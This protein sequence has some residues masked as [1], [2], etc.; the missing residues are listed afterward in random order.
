MNKKTLKIAGWA[1]GLSVAV[2]G[3]GAIA[4]THVNAPVETE[5]L[6]LLLGTYE[7]TGA[8]T[9][10]KSNGAPGTVTWNGGAK[11]TALANNKTFSISGL[12]DYTITDALI[13]IRRSSNSKA[14]ATF[15]WKFDSESGTSVSFDADSFTNSTSFHDETLFTGLSKNGSTF[16][17]VTS[18]TGSS[19]YLESV[20]LY[21]SLNSSDPSVTFNN[22]TS[23]VN[24]GST[25]ANAA[26]GANLGGAAISY[27]SDNEAVA[28]VTSSGV[29]AGVAAGNATITASAVVG[30]VRY[31]DSYNITVLATPVYSGGMNAFDW[32]NYENS[33][34]YTDAALIDSTSVSGKSLSWQASSFET[35]SSKSVFVLGDY[36]T[37]NGTWNNFNGLDNFAHIRLGLAQNNLT[38]SNRTYALFSKNFGV[39]DLNKV[40][41]DW[42]AVVGTG[43]TV[44]VLASSDN[45]LTWSKLAT[46]VTEGADSISWSGSSFSGGTTVE[47]AIVLTSTSTATGDTAPALR[48]VTWKLYGASINESATYKATSVLVNADLDTVVSGET[49]Q[50]SST[51]SPSF[52]SDTVTYS[53]TASNPAGCA[54]VDPNTG[55]ITGVAQGS[56]TITATTSGGKTGTYNVNVGGARVYVTGVS[57]TE[58]E[59][60]EVALNRTLQLHA[61]VMPN[62]ATTDTV[63]WSTDD[64][65]VATVS[66]TGLVS[67]VAQGTVTIT[68]TCNGRT[69]GGQYPAA[70]IV[71][72]IGPN[73]YDNKA[74]AA[75]TSGRQYKIVAPVKNGNT[76][77]NY[78]LHSNG[79]STQPSGTTKSWEATIFTFT[80]VADN[81]WEI[82]NGSD[83]LKFTSGSN[84]NCRVTSGS[85]TWILDN[86]A[87]TTTYAGDWSLKSVNGNNRFLCLYNNEKFQG[88]TSESTNRDANIEFVPFDATEFAQDVVNATST[89]CDGSY[90]HAG[91]DFTTAEAGKTPIW[92]YLTSNYALL[93]SGEKNNLVNATYERNGAT[94]TA[95]GTTTQEIAEGVA[96]HDYLVAKYG[97][98]SIFGGRIIPALSKNIAT[99][100][101]SSESNAASNIAVISLTGLAVGG[102]GCFAFIRR[103]KEER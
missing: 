25:V 91:A 90:D 64:S 10:S 81:T 95:T 74:Q 20:K 55:L 23:E 31:S 46:K 80:L 97:I 36:K 99:S 62:N 34:V 83:Y 19:M 93:T 22:P 68:A 28:T 8:S 52:A 39:V 44:S 84:G 26:I 72:T 70:S 69:E 15:T 73:D 59:T 96:R 18:G 29:V 67:P 35:Y 60:A 57:I 9:A 103:K 92:T 47:V 7:I 30:G 86:A 76:V 102:A 13:S 12:S 87:D 85:D 5:A 17:F 45:G 94:V 65:S 56:A 101:A 100:I 54:T 77:T 43:L 71:I 49:L 88:Y 2:A 58:G 48:N 33:K 82:T 42:S 51:L 41:F 14:A 3:I 53:V 63:T 4:G 40:Q 38:E 21:G 24:V 6:G 79:S 89:V 37:T 50:L 75:L 66:A 11:A 16:S 78:Y 27:A 98:D 61:V 32:S 1:L